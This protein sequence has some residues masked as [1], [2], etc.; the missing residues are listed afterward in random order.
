MTNQKNNKSNWDD[1]VNWLIKIQDLYF[2]AL[3][4]IT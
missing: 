1:K 2:S 3:V 4:V